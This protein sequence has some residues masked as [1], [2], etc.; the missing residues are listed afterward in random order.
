MVDCLSSVNTHKKP[1]T[2][3]PRVFIAVGVRTVFY[4]IVCNLS[5]ECYNLAAMRY[6]R[7]DEIFLCIGVR[8]FD[9]KGF[10]ESRLLPEDK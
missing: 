4:Q 1:P 3:R 6:E 7:T 9:Y 8:G 5:K 2:G 10:L